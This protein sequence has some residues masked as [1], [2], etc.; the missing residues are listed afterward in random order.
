MQEPLEWMD[1][2]EDEQERA[3]L[4]AGSFTGIVVGDART[5]LDELLGEPQGVLVTE[6]VE[7]SPGAAAGLEVGDVIVEAGATKAAALHWPSEWRRLELDV[8]PGAELQLIV[9]RAGR[10]FEFSVTTTARLRA[11]AR[12]AGERFREE[13]RTGVV[14]RAATEVEARKAA[15]GPGGGAVVVGLTLESPWRSAGIVYGDLIRA[16]DGVE[17]AHPQVLLDAVRA[18]PEGAALQLE[19]MRRAALVN[20]DAPL[21]KRRSQVR[22]ISVPLLFSFERERDS[23]ET[24][25]LL[26]ALR[27]RSTPAAWDVRVLWLISFGGGDADQLAV[28]RP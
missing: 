17:V 7:N 1:E 24:S 4:P 3:T 12:E 25:I 13:A 19:I 9:D 15:L 28:E 11:A 5:S 14:V 22:E 8:A 26:G 16:V 2:P 18:A 20:V 23:S 10:E 27:V 21:T 6:V